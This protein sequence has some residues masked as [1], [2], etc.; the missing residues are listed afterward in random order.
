MAALAPRSRA[1][2]LE[3]TLNT[4]ENTSNGIALR[5]SKTDQ[6]AAARVVGIPFGSNPQLCPVRALRRWLGDAG[7]VEGALSAE[8]TVTAPLP[9]PP[10]QTRL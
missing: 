3:H 9:N 10:S 4:A 5:R 7:I 6:K 2:N 1:R 8:W